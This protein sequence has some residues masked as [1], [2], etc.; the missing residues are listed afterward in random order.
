MTLR[1]GQNGAGCFPTVL[2]LRRLAMRKLYI[3]VSIVIC[4]TVGVCSGVVSSR[5][6]QSA[7]TGQAKAATSIKA[8]STPCAQATSSGGPQF[9]PCCQW[10]A[11]NF[12]MNNCIGCFP[13]TNMCGTTE[14]CEHQTCYCLDSGTNGVIY[15]CLLP[16]YCCI[17]GGCNPCS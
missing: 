1:G 8:A 6:S 15:T 13:C 4:L 12:G 16:D 2:G 7:R 11:Q 3:G 10:S 9:M 5:G 14:Q 17:F